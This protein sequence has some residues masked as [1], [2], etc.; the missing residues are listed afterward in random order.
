MRLIISGVI[1]YAFV[2]II[3]WLFG[4]EFKPGWSLG[5]T[6]VAGYLLWAYL[7][8]LP[9]PKDPTPQKGNSDDL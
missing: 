4:G 9:R 7:L 2:F 3:F 6:A 1:A 5:L 8:A